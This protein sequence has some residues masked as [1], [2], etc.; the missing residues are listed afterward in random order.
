MITR[1]YSGQPREA[2]IVDRYQQVVMHRPNARLEVAWCAACAAHGCLLP[3]ELV[4]GDAH[5]AILQHLRTADDRTMPRY[6]RVGL[7]RDYPCWREIAERERSDARQA[8][9]DMRAAEILAR[10]DVA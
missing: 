6:I 5:Y 1:S 10:A 8:H 4:L 9:R 3:H 7:D 2:L